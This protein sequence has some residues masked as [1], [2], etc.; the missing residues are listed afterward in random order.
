MLRASADIKAWAKGTSLALP[1][2]W[3][4]SQTKLSLKTGK[5]VHFLGKGWHVT[6]LMG[7]LC[8]FMNDKPVDDDLKMLAWSGHK[9]MSILHAERKNGLL[10]T[11]EAASQVQTLGE[12]HLNKLLAMNR[13]YNEWQPYK[14]FNI[15]PKVHSMCHILEFAKSTRNAVAQSCW[16]EEDWIRGVSNLAKMTHIRKTHESTLKRYCAGLKL[17]CT[18]NIVCVHLVFSHCRIEIFA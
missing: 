16:M 18:C 13:K 4:L 14:L 1:N 6:A 12:Y 8:D 3:H 7:F 17:L 11:P 9:L 5:H 15:R 10:L 2:R